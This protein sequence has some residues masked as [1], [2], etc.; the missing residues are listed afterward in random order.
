MYPAL[1][2]LLKRLY[3]PFLPSIK[4]SALSGVFG[5]LKKSLQ[6]KP[7]YK[8]A[9][10]HDKGN[11]SNTIKK[12]ADTMT[13]KG[14]TPDDGF[15]PEDFSAAFDGLEEELKTAFDGLEEQLQGLEAELNSE[16]TQAAFRD[17][18]EELKRMD[19]SSDLAELDLSLQDVDLSLDS[20]DL[21]GGAQDGTEQ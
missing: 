7:H 14:F 20:I 19:L 9:D 5:G 13:E 12:G 17:M 11:K 4:K 18:A 21:L 2:A 15:T 6:Q 16:E 3:P 8:K 1:S 10:A